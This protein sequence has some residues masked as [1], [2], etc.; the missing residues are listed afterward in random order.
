MNFRQ[1]I[2]VEFHAGA[3]QFGRREP[4]LEARSTTFRGRWIAELPGCGH[5]ALFDRTP[6]DG[7]RSISVNEFDD[8]VNSDNLKQGRLSFDGGHDTHDPGASSNSSDHTA[9][10]DEHRS[11]RDNVAHGIVGRASL[12]N[13]GYANNVANAD[14]NADALNNNNT[15][16]D[17]NDG[18][19]DAHHDGAGDD[20]DN[21]E[22]SARHEERTSFNPQPRRQHCAESE[23]S[24]DRSLHVRQWRLGV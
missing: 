10:R 11:C 9:Q 6:R 24:S 19:S 4:V 21:C 12:V 3:K 22:S 16:G 17:D 14:D 2:H 7:E 20:N 18:G 23:F 1:L 5:R 13:I 15:S 8:C